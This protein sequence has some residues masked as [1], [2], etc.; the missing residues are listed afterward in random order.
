MTSYD[1][2]RQLGKEYVGALNTGPAELAARFAP[3]ATA[4]I[5]GATLRS[6]IAEAVRALAPPGRSSFR[7]ARLDGP[8]VVWTVRVKTTNAEG[9][10]TNAEGGVV[11][12]AHRVRLNAAEEI[13][14]IVVE[15]A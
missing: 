7:G 12:Q 5:D 6:D 3:G 13:T 14:Q 8:D 15:G 2:A 10:T 9:E 4:R 1:R 11:D